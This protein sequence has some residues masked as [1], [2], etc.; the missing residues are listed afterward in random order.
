MLQGY[1]GPFYPFRFPTIM[2]RTRRLLVY[3]VVDYILIRQDELVNR[4]GEL[5]FREDELQFLGMNSYIV[6]EN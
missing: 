3:I 1:L 2:N 5:I 6:R 4:P